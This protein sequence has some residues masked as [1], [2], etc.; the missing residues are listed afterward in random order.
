MGE[1]NRIFSTHKGHSCNL[2]RFSKSTLALAMVL[3]MSVAVVLLAAIGRR[4]LCST[5]LT[6]R[7]CNARNTSL[8]P[9][10]VWGSRIC[11]TRPSSHAARGPG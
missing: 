6:L 1:N 8:P 11:K 3:V 10:T 9:A 2:M 5:K 7:L 4:N